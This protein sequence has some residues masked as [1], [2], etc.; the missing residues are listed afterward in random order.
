M[1]YIE[2][3][4]LQEE[5]PLHDSSTDRQG[6]LTVVS[7]TSGQSGGGQVIKEVL[8][9][10]PRFYMQLLWLAQRLGFR[11]S[12][13]YSYDI[14]ILESGI[15][16]LILD[17]KCSINPAVVAEWLEQQLYNFQS[18]KTCTEPGWNPARDFSINPSN[19]EI[20]SHYSNS[21]ALGGPWPNTILNQV[22]SIN[23]TQQC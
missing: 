23:T 14:K 19:L 21:R 10:G 1:L 2:W 3:R 7:L 6:W 9:S 15:H 13:R 5:G 20:I 11:A 8:S 22:S 18:Q 12:V 16:I 17:Y 4:S